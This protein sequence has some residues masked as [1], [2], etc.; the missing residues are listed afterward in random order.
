[1][2]TLAAEAADEGDYSTLKEIQECL[3]R[4]YEEQSEEVSDKYFRKTP[5]EFIGQPGV[6]FMS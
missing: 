2:G 4:P 5:H 6:A 1:M 3:E